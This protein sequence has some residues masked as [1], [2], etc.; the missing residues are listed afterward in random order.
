LTAKPGMCVDFIRRVQKIG[1]A[2]DE[3]PEWPCR[4]WYVSLLLAIA[5][6]SRVV[7]WWEAEKGFWQFGEPGEADGSANEEFT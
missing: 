1:K 5:G 6:L 2:W 3:N 7:E 4:G